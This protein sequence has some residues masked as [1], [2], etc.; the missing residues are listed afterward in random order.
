MFN[1]IQSFYDKLLEY[2]HVSKQYYVTRKMTYKSFIT[3][4]RQL[5]KYFGLTYSSQI[6]YIKSNYEIIYHIDMTSSLDSS[7][8]G[9]DD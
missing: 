5:C 1:H 4:L 3:V 6:K 9:N 2:Y 7:T 8:L